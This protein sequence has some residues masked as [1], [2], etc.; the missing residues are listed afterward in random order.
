MAIDFQCPECKA[1]VRVPEIHAGKKASC[2][3]CKQTIRIPGVEK[4]PET[5][6]ASTPAEGEPKLEAVEP[7]K[8]VEASAAANVPVPPVAAP[9]P[10]ATA[11]AGKY[12]KFACPSCAKM[13][14]FE[15]KFAGT[16]QPCPSCKAKVMVP[17]QSDGDSFIVASVPGDKEK[18]GAR[19]VETHAHAHPTHAHKPAKRK[20]ESA[21][22]PVLGALAGV[23]AIGLII[24]AAVYWPRKV[25]TSGTEHASGPLDPKTP[26]STATATALS[27]GTSTVATA[28]PPSDSVTKKLDEKTSDNDG[29]EIGARPE[30]PPAPKPPET[31]ADILSTKERKTGREDEN[32]NATNVPPKSTPNN[33]PS[34][35][36]SEV[37]KELAKKTP[38]PDDDPKPDTSKKPPVASPKNTIA[39]TPPKPFTPAPA[40]NIAAAPAV[41]PQCLGMTYVPIIPAKTYIRFSN[42]PLNAT[43]YAA[44][45]PWR[46]CPKC[47]AGKDA[48]PLV[49]AEQTRLSGVQ[50]INEHWEQLT[51]A[52]LSTV[53]THHVTIRSTM[54]EPEVRGVATALEQLTGQLEQLTQT[55]VLTQTRPDTDELM[56]AWDAQGYL[57]FVN[58][59]MAQEPTQNWAMAQNSGGFLLPHRGVFNANRGAM[60]H[61]K[62][63][64]LYQ[65]GE[66]EIVQA[67]DNKA[68]TWLRY[69]FASYCENVITHKNLVY[70]FQYEKNEVRFSDNWD[71]EIKKYASQGKLKTWDQAFLIQPIGMSSL[72]YLT[73][74]SMVS[75]MMN[76]DAKLFPKYCLALKDGMDSEKAFEKV[77][78]MDVKRLQQMW[79]N[80]AVTR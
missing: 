54:P 48:A 14:G 29:M 21:G 4:T 8:P 36:S 11:T 1:A 18:P 17:D 24:T 34:N 5:A 53:E 49:A 65:F 59:L 22:L 71:N 10:S 19:K 58:A 3:G 41:C 13:T 51:R 62:H 74:Y 47:Q 67:T 64:A 72:D 43:A 35:P 40:P 52:K 9:A 28:K 79:V 27:T 32:E 68:P 2:P 63:M 80:W 44:A 30:A 26:A 37:M 61:P 38:P 69:G 76:T 73:C 57:A 7:P 6:A 60:A 12:I 78:N 16:A 15:A 70:A 75:F 25:P 66:M 39:A 55:V 31:V 45:V 33:D 56:I 50:A 77:Y 23:A 20:T 46:W 42:E